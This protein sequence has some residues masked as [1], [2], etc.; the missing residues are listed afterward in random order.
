[1]QNFT[2]YHIFNLPNSFIE[3][4]SKIYPKQYFKLAIKLLS[5]YFK[6]IIMKFS[7]I[8]I[9]SVLCKDIRIDEV[10]HRC[11]IFLIKYI[12]NELCKVEEKYF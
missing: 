10:Y 5:S 1:M 12:K 9:R 3:T 2:E 11:T 8:L 7:G 4:N 6:L